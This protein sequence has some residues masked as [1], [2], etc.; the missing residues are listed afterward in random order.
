MVALRIGLVTLAAIGLVA[1][2][3]LAGSPRADGPL[4]R[5][6]RYNIRVSLGAGEEFTW[7]VALPFNATPSEVRIREVVLQ[8]PSGLTIL[9]ILATYGM[10]Q[11]DG[12]CLSAGASYGF[13]PTAV[14]ADGATVQFPT[15]SVPG[16][17]VPSEENRTC[18][19]H[20]SV[21]VGVRRDLSTA[22]GR[23]EGL[24]VR[25]EYRGAEYE[26]LLPDS[27]AVDPR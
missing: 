3:A 7:T 6:S 23:I 11:Q 25:Y 9:G 10:R 18:E 19:S 27:L 2:C 21:S 4:Q 12:S 24:R 5:S 13:P 14:S 16:T 8:A 20:P 26:V 15:R 17:I 22:T 1:A